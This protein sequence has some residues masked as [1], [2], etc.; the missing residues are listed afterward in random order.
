[1]IFFLRARP[2]L[3]SDVSG[4]LKNYENEKKTS[5]NQAI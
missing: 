1:M 4:A 3:M 5:I 2:L